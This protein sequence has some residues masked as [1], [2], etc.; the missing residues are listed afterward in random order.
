MSVFKCANLKSSYRLS[1]NSLNELM[2]LETK[3]LYCKCI[4]GL[5]NMN[6]AVVNGARAPKLTIDLQVQKRLRSHYSHAPAKFSEY[7]SV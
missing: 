1:I 3:P 6:S 7:L 5:L 2:N 4:N